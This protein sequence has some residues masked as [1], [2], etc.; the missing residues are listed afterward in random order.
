MDRWMTL[1]IY[2]QTLVENNTFGR[3]CS[4]YME[5]EQTRENNRGTFM[6]FFCFPVFP[7]WFMMTCITYIKRARSMSISLRSPEHLLIIACILI[8][9]FWVEANL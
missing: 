6:H 5:D 8:V 7:L 9:S 3:V 2:Y 1:Y 4:S